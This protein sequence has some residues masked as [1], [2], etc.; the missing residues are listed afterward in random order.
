MKR[1]FMRCFVVVS[2]AA[3][4][5]LFPLLASPHRI[6]EAHRNLIRGG[7][8][9][10]EV[11]SIFGVP[12]GTYDWAVD[13][14]PIHRQLAEYRVRI[15]VAHEIAK[16]QREV[17]KAADETA[18][19]AARMKLALQPLLPS[20]DRAQTWMS[21]HGSVTIFFDNAGHV[22]GIG[23]W[24]KTRVEPRWKKWWAKIRGK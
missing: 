20:L 5:L 21:R 9:V 22:T 17:V 23:G 14:G 1:R 11:E 19:Q 18:R 7:M 12:A 4:T 6:D 24:E 3:I 16:A 10:A 15:Y 13:H 8:T 2:L